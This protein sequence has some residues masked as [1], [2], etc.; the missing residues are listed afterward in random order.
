MIGTIEL[1]QP[2]MFTSRIGTAENEKHKVTV[3]VT[4]PHRSPMI[5]RDDG[6]TYSLSWDDVLKL[7]CA[8]FEE[9][10]S[11][12]EPKVTEG[13]I[14]TAI[15]NIKMAQAF[16][17]AQQELCVLGA[18]DWHRHETIDDRLHDALAALGD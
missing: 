7:A 6:V 12:E 11:G 14:A 9:H 10:D 18:P 4:E 1:K 13:N 15:K 17:T 16:N 3:L 8:A 5:V 2:L